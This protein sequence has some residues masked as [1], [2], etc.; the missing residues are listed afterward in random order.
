VGRWVTA[1]VVG[2]RRGSLG[3]DVGS[4]SLGHTGGLPIERGR[5]RVWL[6]IFVMF[7]NFLEFFS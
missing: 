6:L 2:S 1:W 7:I 5:V 4:G 3:H